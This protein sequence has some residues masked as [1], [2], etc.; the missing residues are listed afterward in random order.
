MSRR[1]PQQKPRLSARE[2]P[3]RIA[4]IIC[5]LLTGATLL[6]TGALLWVTIATGEKQTPDSLQDYFF[7][8]TPPRIE[9]YSIEVETTQTEWLA[10]SP[11]I[12]YDD[13]ELVSWVEH[14]VEESGAQTPEDIDRV[15][16]DL[17]TQHAIYNT[18]VVNGQVEYKGEI[19]PFIDLPNND[20][21]Y[22]VDKKP[23]SQCLRELIDYLEHD[24]PQPTWLCGDFAR[25]YVGLLRTMGFSAYVE[26]TRT[27]DL[28]AEDWTSSNYH[29]RIAVIYPGTQTMYFSDPTFGS[30]SGSERGRLIFYK[31]PATAYQTAE[32]Y[33]MTSQQSRYEVRYTEIMSEEIPLHRPDSRPEDY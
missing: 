13:P 17:A 2:I 15:L 12:D 23:Y 24:G 1:S 28:V 5:I 27:W 25:F 22:Y 8:A 31:L 20:M 18:E 30:S 6:I 19:I 16:Y 14:Y 29:A 11:M 7:G 26:I 33:D 10:S 32:H 9:P 21:G 3:E 4:L